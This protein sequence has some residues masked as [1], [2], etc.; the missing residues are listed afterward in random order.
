MMCP[1]L[2]WPQ[3]RSLHA[4]SYYSDIA[5]LHPNGSESGDTRKGGASGNRPKRK[6]LLDADPTGT[7]LVTVPALGAECVARSRL[8]RS[9]AP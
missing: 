9:S 5:P 8:A 6:T 3:L 2:A 4:A 1:W 7:E